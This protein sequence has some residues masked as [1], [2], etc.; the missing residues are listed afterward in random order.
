V[1]SKYSLHEVLNALDGGHRRCVCVTNNEVS[2]V[3]EKKFIDQGLRQ[4]H[5]V[6]SLNQR[7]NQELTHQVFVQQNTLM[8]PPRHKECVCVTNNE[9][10]AVEEKK[11]IDQGLRQG[12]KKWEEHGIISI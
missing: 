2:A 12:D 10:S 5:E 7:K 1:H 4:G 8:Y 9:V 11:F 3:E 6:L